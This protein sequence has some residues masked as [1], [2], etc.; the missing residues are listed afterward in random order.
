MPVAIEGY[1]PPYDPRIAVLK[2]TPD[3]GVIEVNIQP[4]ACWDELVAQ[5]HRPLCAWRAKRV[6]A[7]KS[8]C[9][10]ARH[11]GTGGGNHVVIGAATAED[12]P[13][14]RRPDLLRSL[15]G[16]WQ[17]HP[18]L[19]YLFSGLFIGPTSQHPRVDEARMDNR[20]TNSKSLSARCPTRTTATSRHG[21]STAFSAICWSTS[22]ATRTAPNCASTSSIRRIR[23]STRLGLVEFRAFEMPPHARMSLAQQLLVRALIAHFWQTLGQ[24]SRRRRLVPWGT[25][26]HDRFM[27]P[28]FIELDFED[29]LEEL[30]D[31]GYPFQ[32]EWFAPHFEFRFPAIGSVT[33]RGITLELRSALEPWNVLGEE[34]SAGGTAR[35]VDSSVERLQVKVTGMIEAALHACCATAAGCPCSQPAFPANPW[36]VSAIAPGSRRRVCI[37]IFRF[38]RRWCLISWTHGRG[39]QSGAARITCR[40]P[41]AARTNSFL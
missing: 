24:Q 7:R 8:S 21:W 12:S 41:A 10:T 40:I 3:P 38:I 4:A 22:P 37:P 1:T 25:A 13:F 26:L 29:V 34:T 2:V 30:S 35:N 36:R 9:S 33:K 5:H 32:K 23:A 20:S 18:S 14:L 11:S 31:A 27:L 15:V 39:G 16:F 17:N 19:S 6:W 28:H